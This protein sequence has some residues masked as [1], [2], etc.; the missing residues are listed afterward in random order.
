MIR[1]HPI[2]VPDSNSD[3]NQGR[4]GALVADESRLNSCH[5]FKLAPTSNDLCDTRAFSV[6]FLSLLPCLISVQSPS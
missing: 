6:T 4:S 2:K 3:D 1:R 5:L